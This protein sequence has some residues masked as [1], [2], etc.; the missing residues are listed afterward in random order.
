MIRRTCIQRTVSRLS[1]SQ[2]LFSTRSPALETQ[3]HASVQKPPAYVNDKLY[4]QAI[5]IRSQILAT[6]LSQ[7]V[8]VHG[9]SDASITQACVHH[10]LPSVSVKMVAGS[11][12]S[13]MALIEFAL[14]RVDADWK[15][16]AVLMSDSPV[17]MDLSGDKKVVDVDFTNQFYARAYHVTRDRLL[18]MQPLM[19]KWGDVWDRDARL[20]APLSVDIRAVLF[21]SISRPYPFLQVRGMSRQARAI[22]LQLPM[23]FVD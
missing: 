14:D 7:Y 5:A 1:L 22:L 23:I 17:D 16:A 20:T 9:W 4:P 12:D 2:R 15:E 8:P 10:G 3:E 19:P 21:I 6:A 11:K 13:D 18:R